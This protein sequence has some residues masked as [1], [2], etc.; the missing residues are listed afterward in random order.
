MDLRRASF[1]ASLR[2]A[3]QDEEFSLMP[4]KIKPHAE[5]RRGAAE[6]RLGKRRETGKE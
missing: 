5:E 1:E 3:P 4:S 2:E 6:A